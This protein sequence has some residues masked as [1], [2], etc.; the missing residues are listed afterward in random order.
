LLALTSTGC[1]TVCNL[2]G[3]VLNPDSEPR[4]YGGVQRDMAALDELVHGNASMP[5]SGCNGTGGAYMVAAIL[6]FCALDP[7]LALIGDTLTLPITIPLSRRHSPVPRENDAPARTDA[8]A[9]ISAAAPSR[10]ATAPR[11]PNDDPP[12]ER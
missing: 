8:A 3:G 2:A 9:S 5:L 12:D 10:S 1:G 11:A 7:A 4:V 6:G